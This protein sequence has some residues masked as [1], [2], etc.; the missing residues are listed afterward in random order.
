M[1]VKFQSQKL[2]RAQVAYISQAS[3][4]EVDELCADHR[5]NHRCEARQ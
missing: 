5:T 1:Y 4:G 2:S 3:D